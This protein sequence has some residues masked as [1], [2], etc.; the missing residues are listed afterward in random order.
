MKK[1]TLAALVVAA[2][3]LAAGCQATSSTTGTSPTSTNIGAATISSLSSGTWASLSSEPL[4]DTLV[5]AP[6]SCGNFKWGITTLTL[7]SATGTFSANCGGGQVLS[8]NASVTLNGLTAVW[9]G[10]GTVTGN[11]APC[12]FSV[13][14]T[15]V[16]ET[17]GVRV[18][19]D[20]TVCGT[21][22]T[23]SE[24]LKKR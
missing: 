12:T 23:G 10:N 22:I 16:Q 18:T 3:L 15:A 17:G 6:A 24:L 20:A 9:G 2:A 5:F 7:V 4:P 11:G 8:G 19:Y 13:A 21:R 14:G 1:W